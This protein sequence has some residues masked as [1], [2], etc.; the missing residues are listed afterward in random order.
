MLFRSGKGSSGNVHSPGRGSYDK[1]LEFCL[2]LNWHVLEGSLS[3]PQ[4]FSSCS[5]LP[6]PNISCNKIYF[7]NKS[8]NKQTNCAWGVETEADKIM[9]LGRTFCY[10]FKKLLSPAANTYHLFQFNSLSSKSFTSKG[11]CPLL[12]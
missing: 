12:Q 8:K 3:L 2:L 4:L 6:H 9:K 7:W 11:H 10:L 1:V 5:S